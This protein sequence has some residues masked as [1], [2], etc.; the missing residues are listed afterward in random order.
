[1]ASSKLPSEIHTLCSIILH[2]YTQDLV[3]TYN[4]WMQDPELLENTGSEAL[5]LQE[6][7][8]NQVSWMEDPT[9][10]TFIILDKA[11]YDSKCPANSMIGDINLFIHSDGDGEINVMI[12]EKAYRGKGLAKEAVNFMIEFG[13]SRLHLVRIL[14]KILKDNTPSI[15]MFQKLG[16]TLYDEIEDFNEVHYEFKL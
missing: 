6:E 4:S 2:P 9:K 7:Y 12:A 8:E 3:N 1:M 11:S 16:F 15:A 5:S 14:A 10:Y 13:R